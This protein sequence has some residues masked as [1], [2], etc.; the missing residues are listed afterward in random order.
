[1]VFFSVLLSFAASVS[2]LLSPLSGEEVL[3]GVLL[4]V[5]SVFEQAQKTEKIKITETRSAKSLFVFENI[6]SSSFKKIFNIS[7]TNKS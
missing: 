7:Y 1:M 6:I 2:L 4:S 3:S 5:S